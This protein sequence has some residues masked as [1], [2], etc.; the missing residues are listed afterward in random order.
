MEKFERE[1]PIVEKGGIVFDDFDVAFF[2]GARGVVGDRFEEDVKETKESVEDFLG[3]KWEIGD[4]KLKLYL[5]CDEN[6]YQEYLKTHFPKIPKDW[7]TFD[8]KTN[9]ILNCNTIPERK[10]DTGICR[11]NI[12]AG[13]GHE[14]AH[15]HPF[16]GGVGNK[17]SKGKWEQEMVCVFIEDKIRAKM[18]NEMLRKMNFENA[19]KELEQF[20]KEGK[21]F[22]LKEVDI[23]WKNFYSVE[24]FV[25]PWLEK[26]Y[27]IEKLR[28]LWTMLFKEKK[29]IGESL[30][31]IYGEK[32]KD[33]EKDFQEDIV[34]AKDYKE[35]LE[36]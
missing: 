2:D 26:K 30:K 6:Q 35:I 29:E 11:A 25:Y 17:A 24:R 9:S 5:F 23:D 32:A 8:Q 20:K 12:F 18:G 28:Q 33:M 34:Q 27:G 31:D 16:F 3:S 14:M 15:L 36:D 4:N 7:A 22:S 19:K 10:E 21:N 1:K 13:V